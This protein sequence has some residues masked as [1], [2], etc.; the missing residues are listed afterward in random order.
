MSKYIHLCRNCGLILSDAQ[1]KKHTAINDSSLPSTT[2]TVDGWDIVL[3]R[4]LPCWTAADTQN[5]NR[6][7]EGQFFNN[8]K[9]GE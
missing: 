5:N 3:A 2:Y 8:V 1:G 6:E 4:C 7:L 9:F